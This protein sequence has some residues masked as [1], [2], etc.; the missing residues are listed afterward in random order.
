MR[1]AKKQENITH[2]Q[3]TEQAIETV[4]ER[5][6]TSELTDK[7]FKTAIANL[8]K[9]PMETILKEV[10]EDIMTISHQKENINKEIQTKR[11][12]MDILEL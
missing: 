9:E 12:Q 8:F 1:H 7:D 3:E 2:T 5:A 6:Q 10:T 4:C 11:N